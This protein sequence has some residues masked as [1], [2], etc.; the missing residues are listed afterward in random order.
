MSPERTCRLDIRISRI[1]RSDG[2]ARA[3]ATERV[4]LGVLLVTIC[5]QFFC[6]LV[7]QV[8]WG[9]LDHVWVSRMLAESRSGLVPGRDTQWIGTVGWFGVYGTLP[10]LPPLARSFLTASIPNGTSRGLLGLR[11][12]H[13]RYE[14]RCRWAGHATMT[15]QI[16]GRTRPP[17]C[18]YSHRSP[19]VGADDRSGGPPA[20]SLPGRTPAGQADGGVAKQHGAQHREW[21]HQQQ[22]E[23]R[24]LLPYRVSKGMPSRTAQGH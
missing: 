5:D 13:Q 2:E 22:K 8:N 14:P 15:T 10:R 24:G 16:P 19:S 18:P 21:C 11:P 23:E 1:E 3:I 12:F 17:M 9:V 4:R 6:P 20:S 7:P